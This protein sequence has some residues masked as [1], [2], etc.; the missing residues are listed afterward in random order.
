[1][2]I[3]VTIRDKVGKNFI[4]QETIFVKNLSESDLRIIAQRCEA[5][6][7]ST[8]ENTMDGGTGRLMDA[9]FAE[10]C[11]YGNTVA[12]GVGDIPFLNETVPYWRHVNYGSE[13]I[14]ANWQ[15][16]LPKGN[17]VN[18]RWVQNSS[19]YSGIQPKTPVPARNYIEKTL[20]RMEIEI[21]KIL[22]DN[23]IRKI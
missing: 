19:G 14:G 8:I 6:I 20:A 12:W 23:L 5:I 13:A 3:R 16:F 11:S 15:H 7:K 2:R 21:P 17:W 18:G 4:Q 1:M 22:G 9:W 10:N